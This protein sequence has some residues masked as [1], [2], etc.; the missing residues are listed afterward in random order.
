MFDDTRSAISG[1]YSHSLSEEV[2][3]I[4]KHRTGRREALRWAS[5]L[6]FLAFDDAADDSNLLRKQQCSRCAKLGDLRDAKEHQ[7]EVDHCT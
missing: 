6:R 2:V 7:I 1:T 4:A 3:D 5:N